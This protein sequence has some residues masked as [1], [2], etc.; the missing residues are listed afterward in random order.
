MSN[1]RD[2]L[3]EEIERET[4]NST[5][6]YLNGYLDA[7]SLF[8][9]YSVIGMNYKLFAIDLLE[10]DLITS[11]DHQA[12]KLFDCPQGAYQFELE[13]IVYWKS[14]IKEELMANLTRRILSGNN[15]GLDYSVNDLVKD[16]HHHYINAFD[17]FLSLLDDNLLNKTSEAYVVKANGK[18]TFHS[19]VGVD[20][21][22]EISST[23]MIYL[24]LTGS[25]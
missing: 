17:I 25:D 24:Q 19:I 12:Y 20:L 18:R 7:L 16:M 23:Q 2:F 22:F 8:N 6:L 15:E 11:I 1:T 9:S 14:L 10:G 4:I 5:V 3:I 13:S 21:V